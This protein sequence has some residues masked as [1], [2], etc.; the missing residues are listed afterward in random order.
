[1]AQR[2]DLRARRIEARL[3][4]RNVFA[5][6][7]ASGDELLLIDIGTA[8]MARDAILPAVERLGFS[9]DAVRFVVFTHPDLDHQGGLAVLGDAAPSAVTACG[10]LDRAMVRR[11]EQLVSDRYQQYTH[12]HGVGFDDVGVAWMRANYGGLVEIDLTFVGGER[13]RVGDRVLEV[14][15][16]AGHSAGHLMLFEPATRLLFC[17]DAIHTEHVP[18]RRWCAGERKGE[19]VWMAWRHWRVLRIL[20]N[21]RYA[22]ASVYG[23]RKQRGE[24]RGREGHAARARLR[25]QWIALI[26]DT[27]PGIHHLRTVRD[28]T[29]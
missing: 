16:A 5:Y 14:L 13:L 29:S 17:S 7:L 21:H 9:F 24:H 26:P 3:G 12:E 22:G 1:M 6:L 4:E 10:F 27:P 28:P 25:E 2:G 19:L 15:P 18:V 23:R 20:H 11:P 8:G